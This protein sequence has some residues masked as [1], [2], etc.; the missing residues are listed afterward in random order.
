MATYKH[1]AALI[2]KY[3]NNE[4]TDKERQE[5]EQWCALSEKNRL[6][7]ER[8]NDDTY[9][10][11][12]RKRL[13]SI[14]IE[15]QWEKISAKLP[16]KKPGRLQALAA[17]WKVAAITAGLLLGAGAIWYWTNQ[18]AGPATEEA[19]VQPI[20]PVQEQK[21]LTQTVSKRIEL[22]L[23]N[24]HVVFLDGKSDGQVAKQDHATIYK[25][26]EW[27]KYQYAASE[28]QG[29]T[30]YNT[31]STPRGKSC[32]LELSDG[33]RVW[34]NAA[35][36]ITYPTSF[37]GT[38]R[39]VVVTGE[40]YFEIV[41]QQVDP[42]RH[43][44]FIVDVASVENH[45]GSRI[46]VLGT[47]FNVNAY[48]DE[49]LLTTTLLEGKVKVAAGGTGEFSMLRPGQQA[50]INGKGILKVLKEVEVNGAVAW[51]RDQFKYDEQDIAII[52][53]EIARWYDMEVVF[54]DKVKGHLSITIS[55]Q[56]P[57][58]T[59]LKILESTGDIRFSIE[60]KRIIVAGKV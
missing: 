5:L 38:E 3:R 19:V 40:V 9:L 54:K 15:T 58:E 12:K 51:T 45:A 49:P 29:D 24:G 4:L 36:S 7:F 56:T 27:I 17:Q 8:L 14:D 60:G 6:L 55:K 32:K 28:Q 31:I 2:I 30:A 47:H 59:L 11:L 10:A 16:I 42:M 46:E 41:H 1:I 21:P 34:V 35:S 52:M 22:K 48:S 39:K 50:Q 18:R 44:P 26:G 33:S 43:I 13:N 37:T 57:V 53:R 25:Q 20:T 23:A